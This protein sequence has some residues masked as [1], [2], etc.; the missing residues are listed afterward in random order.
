MALKGCS[1][2][3]SFASNA[4]GS[5]LHRRS[6]LT[7]EKS[8]RERA[9]ALVRLNKPGGIR[10]GD[11]PSVRDVDRDVEKLADDA[12]AWTEKAS[13]IGGSHPALPATTKSV[14]ENTFL[15]CREEVRR[16]LD[17]RLKS[18]SEFLG[19]DEPIV[20]SGGDAM[21]LDTRYVLYECLCRNFRT[22]VPL[23]PD[24]VAHLAR[25]VQQRCGGGGGVD[26]S[27]ASDVIFGNDAWPSYDGL[28]KSYIMV[29]VEVSGLRGPPFERHRWKDCPMLVGYFRGVAGDFR[30]DSGIHQVRAEML[31][32]SCRVR[33]ALG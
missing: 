2:L 27:L 25:A 3:R 19:D 15:V 17:R 18:L 11:F 33:A 13:A 26:G 23:E 6:A 10:P 8:R 29:F 20:L 28:V 16:C 31:L 21:N 1:K 30:C 5:L 9:E 14:L 32:R 22:I 7:A 4:L 12:L 24:R